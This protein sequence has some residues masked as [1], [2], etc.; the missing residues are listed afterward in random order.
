M[1]LKLSDNIINDKL[2][3]SNI[4]E[5]EEF[6]TLEKAREVES[7]IISQYQFLD[8]INHMLKQKIILLSNKDSVLNITKNGNTN[9]L[10][11]KN[12]YIEKHKNKP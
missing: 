12:K 5:F 7:T 6:E 1:E 2:Y 3:Y 4:A 10:K 11:E 9:Y 8:S